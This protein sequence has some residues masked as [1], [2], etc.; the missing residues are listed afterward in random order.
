[1][2][3]PLKNSA[4]N[5]STQPR[6]KIPQPTLSDTFDVIVQAD[7]GDL[8]WS[9]LQGPRVLRST[10]PRAPKAMHQVP[11]DEYDYDGD[12]EEASRR[13]GLRFPTPKGPRASRQA[14]GRSS[15]RT[16]GNGAVN[17]PPGLNTTRPGT[18]TRDRASQRPGQQPMGTRGDVR[19]Q[20][21]SRDNRNSGSGMAPPRGGTQAVRG[22]DSQP[23]R[24]YGVAKYGDPTLQ[25]GGSFKVPEGPSLRMGQDSAR[26]NLESQTGQFFDARGHALVLQSLNSG[27]WQK[28]E[29]ATRGGGS[30]PQRSQGGSKRGPQIHKQEEGTLKK[31]EI[32]LYPRPHSDSEELSPCEQEAQKRIASDKAKRAAHGSK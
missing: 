7:P 13:A 25:G 31:K 32:D 9:L 23:P 2:Q 3:E 12:E 30:Q 15:S 17:K 24:D 21:R 10:A 11:R 27:T 14:A 8:R 29:Q 20:P 16:R 28:D 19:R 22:R 1:M 6:E 5:E 4:A 18:S 26:N